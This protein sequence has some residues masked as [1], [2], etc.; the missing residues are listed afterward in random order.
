MHTTAYIRTTT[1]VRTTTARNTRSGLIYQIFVWTSGASNRSLSDGVLARCS[2]CS[3]NSVCSLASVVCWMAPNMARILHI[4]V[5]PGPLTQPRNG[6]SR[7]RYGFC[8]QRMFFCPR[9]LPA[10]VVICMQQQESV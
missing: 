5:I 7:T 9:C 3:Y 8:F 2:H 10:M 6:V 1:A 4:S